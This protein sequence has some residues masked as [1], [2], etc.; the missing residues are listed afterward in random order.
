MKSVSKTKICISA[1]YKPDPRISVIRLVFI[2]SLL[3]VSF[4]DVI[5]QTAAD[6]TA[7]AGRKMVFVLPDGRL[8]AP[9]RFDSLEHAWGKGR[10]MFHHSEADDEKGI[11]HLV[12]VTDE[13]KAKSD[14]LAIEKK[15]MLNALLNKPAPDF[16]LRDINGKSWALKA[17]RGKIVVLN[18]WFTSCIPCIQEMP[19]LNKLVALYKDKPVVFLALTFN[20]VKQIKIFQ[21]RKRF[22]YTLLA[23]SKM[24]D[25]QYAVTSWPTSFVIDQ[26][27]VVRTVVQSDPMIKEILN[28]AIRLLLT[29][30][31][32]DSAIGFVSL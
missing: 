1:S 7:G 8:L 20:N 4:N 14:S 27:G 2:I 10:I 25:E 32:T 3:N 29:S 13:M 23:D 11:M 12:R 5:G 21:Q 18:F 22:D 16:N 17:L 15:R 9:D 24:V 19:E 6:T 26:T 31:R 30:H 28:D